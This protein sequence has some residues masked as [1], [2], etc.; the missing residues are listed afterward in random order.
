MLVAACGSAATADYVDAVA[1]TT[2]Q[3][4]RDTFAALP[5]GAAPTRDAVTGVVAA[6]RTALTVITALEPPDDITPEHLALVT[7]FAAF[8]ERSEAFLA[9]TADLDATAFD[10]AVRSAGTLDDL[11]A[12]M[13]A[14]CTAWERRAAEVAHPVELGC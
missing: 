14:A 2:E 4:T 6:R 7:T 11:A 3:M 9:A 8:V 5:P 13:G 12:A 10:T 1:A